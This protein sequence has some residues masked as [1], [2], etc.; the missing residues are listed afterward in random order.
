MIDYQRLFHVGVRVPDLDAAMAELGDSSVN[1]AVRSWIKSSDYAPASH[2]V[3]ER[4]KKA[5]DANGISIPFP[6]R[7]VHIYKH[8]DD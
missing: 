4:I 2:E 6:Q 3:T 5:L 1:L 8:D 7:D